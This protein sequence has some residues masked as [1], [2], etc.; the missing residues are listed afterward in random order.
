MDSVTPSPPAPYPITGPSAPLDGLLD[1]LGRTRANRSPSLLVTS[2]HT[3]G[4]CEVVGK[5]SGMPFQLKLEHLPRDGLIQWALANG[6]PVC[7]T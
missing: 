3:D 2:V 1:A 6:V 4:T 7:S 5:Y